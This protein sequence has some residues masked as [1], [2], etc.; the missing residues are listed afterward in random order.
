[1][2]KQDFIESVVT[3]SIIAIIIIGFLIKLFIEKNYE[4]IAYAGIVFMSEALI[5]AIVMAVIFGGK[6]L[7]H[8]N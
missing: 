6:K 3:L 4:M 2:K 5:F 8:S 1:M 7:K